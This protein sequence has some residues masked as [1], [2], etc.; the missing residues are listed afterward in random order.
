MPDDAEWSVHGM[1][2]RMMNAALQRHEF[3]RKLR[4]AA[5]IDSLTG[6]LNR[7]KLFDLL[8]ADEHLPG[9]LLYLIDLDRFSWVNN[10][11]GHRAGDETVA[12][13]ARALMKV[14]PP[15]AIIARLGG[16]EFVVW[17]PAGAASHD[18]AQLGA[19]ISKA[20]VVPAGEGDG[21]VW[22][23]ASI[24]MI[25]VAVGE[26]AA[27]ALNRADVAMYASKRS[28]GGGVTVG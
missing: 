12:A 14:C 23:R 8:E 11:L 6:L 4:R 1:I 7:R 9:S 27:D 21:R 13:V 25:R 5:E 17:M 20:M 22:V 10:N 15:D 24:G 16:D 2:C 3:D 19:Q 28:G 26:S 18:L